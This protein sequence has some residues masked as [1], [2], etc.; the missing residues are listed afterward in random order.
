MEPREIL[1]RARKLIQDPKNWIQEHFYHNGAYCG[2]GA[3]I[4]AGLT[5]AFSGNPAYESLRKAAKTNEQFCTFNDTHTHA[6]VLAAFDRAIA[7]FD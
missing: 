6:E 3:L 2:S 7:S 5:G 4:A 1:I